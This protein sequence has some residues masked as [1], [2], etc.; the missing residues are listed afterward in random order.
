[1]FEY[2]LNAV[3]CFNAVQCLAQKANSVPRHTKAQLNSQLLVFNSQFFIS[4]TN[5]VNSTQSLLASQSV[6]EFNIEKPTTVF[7]FFSQKNC[8]ATL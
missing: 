5:Y 3:A 2:V 7:S 6:A 1:M 4:I 8:C